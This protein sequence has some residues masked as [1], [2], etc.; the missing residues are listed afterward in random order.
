[1]CFLALANP[2]PLK[3][4]LILWSNRTPHLLAQRYNFN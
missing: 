4:F 3:R 1:V 2:W